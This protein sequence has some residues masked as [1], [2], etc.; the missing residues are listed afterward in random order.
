MSGARNYHYRF[1]SW[2][3]DKKVHSYKLKTDVAKKF[4]YK[5]YLKAFARASE[6]AICRNLFYLY[7]D[8][9]LPTIEEIELEATKLI[10]MGFKNK[11]GKVLIRRNK[12]ANSS[13]CG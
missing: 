7:I 10:K 13:S 1:G 9:Q 12:H 11:K 3:L 2:Y 4:L 5:H 8:L 6:N